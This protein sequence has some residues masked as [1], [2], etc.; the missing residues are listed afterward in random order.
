MSNDGMKLDELPDVLTVAEVA[1]FLRLST[2]M[3]YQLIREEQFK[4]IHYGRAIRV[5]K[6]DLESYLTDP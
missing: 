6:T 5:L 2:R 4:A 1:K 3:I